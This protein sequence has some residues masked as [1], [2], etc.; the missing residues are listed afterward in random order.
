[1]SLL[2]RLAVSPRSAFLRSFVFSVSLFGAASLQAAS[3]THYG[4][5]SDD[6]GT[7]S[8]DSTDKGD[9]S[10]GV[11]AVSSMVT[12]LEK[13]DDSLG[14]LTDIEIFISPTHPVMHTLGGSMTV[15]ETDDK[16]PAGFQGDVFIFAN[17]WLAY[18][19]LT[20]RMPI[21]NESFL[22]E[23]ACA[24]A[25]GDGTCGSIVEDA[26]SG[27]LDGVFV[28]GPAS[29]FD[30]VDLADF[31]APGPGAFVDTLFI[32]LILSE[33]GDFFTANATA[34]AEIDYNIFFDAGDSDPVIG[35]TY[36]YTPVPVPAAG[37]LMV[38]GVMGL[39]ALRRKRS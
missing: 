31:V 14:S 11:A 35:V 6:F 16:V 39:V 5:F 34:T 22:L 17:L 33:F 19:T 27:S 37:W 29:V 30:T 1:M 9:L 2:Q 28:D 13:F 36:T 23:G 15:T 10:A 8:Y 18:I 21:F 12:G 24:G 25:M 3:V 4:D 26:S 38:S 32:E 20:D 7:Y